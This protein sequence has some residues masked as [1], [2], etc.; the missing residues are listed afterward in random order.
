MEVTLRTVA[1]VL[2][3][4]TGVRIGGS[5]PKQLLAVAGKPVI[6][7][8]IDVFEAAPEVDEILVVMAQG[9]VGAAEEIVR[10][11][12]YRKVSAVLEG[13][14]TRTGSTHRAL[15]TL[16]RRY[17]GEE[18]NVLLHDAARPFLAGDIVGR[19]VAALR[20]NEAVAVAIPS[21]DTILVVDEPDGGGD[22][23][24]AIPERHRLRRAQTPQGFRL[25]AI[26]TAYDRAMADPAYVATDDCGVVLRYLPDMPIR[27][28][29]GSEHNMKITHPMDLAIADMLAE[30]VGLTELPGGARM[31]QRADDGG[32]SS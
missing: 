16:V 2:A 7:H 11:G 3:G 19:C 14:T 30:L 26:A 20:T 24:T 12:G 27:V 17:D 10:R 1:V 29:T 13:G 8:A 6:E 18:C 25:S 22:V 5:V 21:S 4:G 31:P 9:F 23:V 32:N 15:Q 28:V